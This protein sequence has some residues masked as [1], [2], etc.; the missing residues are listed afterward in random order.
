M[1]RIANAWAALRGKPIYAEFPPVGLFELEPD[2]KLILE[3]EQILT[4]DQRNH[5]NAYM[6]ELLRDDTNAC[7]VLDGGIRLVAIRKKKNAEAIDGNPNGAKPE[8]RR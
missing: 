4:R 1:G 7:V 8:I 5:L 3:C 6:T 2:D